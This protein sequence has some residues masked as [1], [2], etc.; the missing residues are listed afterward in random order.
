LQQ[1][2]RRFLSAADEST[3]PVVVRRSIGATLFQRMT[4]FLFGAGLTALVTQYF[5]FEELKNGNQIMLTKQK[6]LEQRLT[7]LEES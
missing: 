2:C 7:K 3:K 4:S 1:L 6:E 5:I